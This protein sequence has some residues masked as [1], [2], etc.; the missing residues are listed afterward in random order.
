MDFQSKII[1]IIARSTAFKYVDQM[2]ACDGEFL[3][4]N[5][6]TNMGE[7]N[8]IFSFQVYWDDS[9]NLQI[10]KI[11]DIV[12]F[13]LKKIGAGVRSKITIGPKIGFVV[14]LMRFT[15]MHL[16]PDRITR[17]C[18]YHQK[19]KFLLLHM[20]KLRTLCVLHAR[21]VQ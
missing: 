7:K 20:R 9:I 21:F 1:V 13:H 18:Q 11:K 3:E 6:A 16:I 2:R 19:W 15:L 4:L 12:K 10:L 8:R 14:N 17:Q 5:W